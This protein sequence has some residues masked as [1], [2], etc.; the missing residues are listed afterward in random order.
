MLDDITKSCVDKTIIATASNHV[1]NSISLAIRK[2]YLDLYNDK[3]SFGLKLVDFVIRHDA[4]L[5]HKFW[6]KAARN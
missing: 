3:V 1:D 4:D 6:N 2:T 5:M